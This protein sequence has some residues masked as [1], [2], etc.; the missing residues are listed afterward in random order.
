MILY[1][2]VED[3]NG[4]T[5]QYSLFVNFDWLESYVEKNDWGDIGTFLSE[6]NSEDVNE[7]IS[8]LDLDNEPY[9]IR[10]ECSFFGSF[11]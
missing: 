8:E 10:E 5:Q 6:Y 9:T 4:F 1:F 7:I 3:E 11:D 2:E